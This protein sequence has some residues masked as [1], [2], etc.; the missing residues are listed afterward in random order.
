MVSAKTGWHMA[1][2]QLCHNGRHI[3]PAG[4]STRAPGASCIP[5]HEQLQASRQCAAAAHVV[6]LNELLLALATEL[7]LQ[8]RVAHHLWRVGSTQSG[9]APS[10]G[11]ASSYC[12]AT[13]AICRTARRTVHVV[14]QQPR[15]GRGALL[16]TCV[17]FLHAFS[18]LVASSLG[19]RLPDLERGSVADM[20]HSRALPGQREHTQR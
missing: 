4:S 8:G 1:G 19:C 20:L 7:V 6:P 18:L 9:Q 15:V 11:V 14:P 17:C 2:R 5:S 3:K 13:P 16:L 12:A 10:R